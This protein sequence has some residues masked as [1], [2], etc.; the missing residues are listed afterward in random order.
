METRLYLP[1]AASAALAGA[2]A[3]APRISSA[4]RKSKKRVFLTVFATVFA[5]IM[6]TCA[7]LAMRN[8]EAAENVTGV[9]GLGLLAVGAG[10]Y[11]LPTLIAHRKRNSQAIFVLNLFLGWT[12]L[13]WV[14]ALVWACMRDPDPKTP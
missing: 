8:S 5:G 10:V 6:L 13:G 14:I 1:Q 3:T 4:A 7:Y 2:I 11:F 9:L 12:F